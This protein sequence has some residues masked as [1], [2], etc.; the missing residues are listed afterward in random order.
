MYK[1]KVGLD[2]H[3]NIQPFKCEGPLTDILSKVLHTRIYFEYK[4]KTEYPYAIFK[5]KTCEKI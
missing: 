2:I 1:Y 5:P 3:N 4:Q